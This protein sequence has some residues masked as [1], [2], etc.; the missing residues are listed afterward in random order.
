MLQATDVDCALLCGGEVAPADAEVGSGAD[1]K[2]WEWSCRMKS[3]VSSHAQGKEGQM[4]NE[5][6]FFSFVLKY[7]CLELSLGF[8]DSAT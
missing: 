4:H 1:L 2:I 3:S 8:S 7:F 5:V 6:G